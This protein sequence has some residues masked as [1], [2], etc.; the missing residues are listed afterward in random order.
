MEFLKA[1]L[2]GVNMSFLDSYHR[3]ILNAQTTGKK[4]KVT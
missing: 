1:A 4:K 3:D 2:K